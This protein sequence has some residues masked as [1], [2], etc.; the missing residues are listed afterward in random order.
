MDLT[1]FCIVEK[2][3]LLRAAN[4]TQPD[5]LGAPRRLDVSSVRQHISPYRTL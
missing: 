3:A 4:K 2:T 1:P 5:R